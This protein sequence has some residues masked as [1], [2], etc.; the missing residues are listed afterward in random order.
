MK[1]GPTVKP[2]PDVVVVDD[3][4]R[5]SHQV[6]AS[7]ARS[8]GAATSRSA[9][10]RTKRRPPP[11]SSPPSDG[12]RYVVAGDFALWET[13]GTIT[14][15]GRG[16]M[17]INSGGEKVF[18]EEVEAALKSHADVF[19][20]LVVGATDERWG[21]RVAAVVQPRPGASPT[22]DDLSSHC[23]TRIAGYKVP[24]EL[25]LV[26]AIVRSPS[27]KP[28][29]P[30]AQ[31]LVAAL[32][33]AGAYEHPARRLR[34]GAVPLVA[35]VVG[36]AAVARAPRRRRARLHEPLD[37]LVAVLALA[38]HDDDRPVPVPGTASSTTASSTTTSRS[39]PPRRP[40]ARCSVTPATGRATS[41]SGTSTV[42]P[43]PPMEAYGY[44]DWEGND[45][46]FMGWAGH[47]CRVRPGHRRL[48]GRMVAGQRRVGAIR[49]SSPLRS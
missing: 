5:S 33:E 49:G 42:G 39:T 12:R 1:G 16:S 27:G 47:G 40:S 38:G 22:L 13:D 2:A 21:Q 24:R 31:E 41:A 32:P 6:A 26:D 44:S 18:P 25:H 10:T 37:A 30:W 35:A 36:L 19:D 15:L 46:H 9:T 43:N 11:R 17:C 14:L 7:W 23:R 3:D 34:P 28:D 45:R 29:Y 48:G 8:P 4:L 20:A